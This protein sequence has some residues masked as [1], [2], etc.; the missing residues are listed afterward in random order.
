MPEPASTTLSAPRMALGAETAD[1]EAAG[2]GGRQE[3]W[4]NRLFGRD[5][6]LWSSD[7]RV[8]EA[9]ADRL[10]WLDAPAH[11]TEQIPSLEG[12]GDAV[13]DEGYQTAVVAGM[14]GSSL[15]PDVFAK[16]FGSEEGY[17]D[18]RVLDSTDP[19]FVSATLDDLDP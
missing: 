6:S 18:L 11:F 5:V 17:L 10:G 16:T 7:E 9:I 8:G 2:G 4:V 1:F 12:F 15:A 19:A 3:E 13:V 14:G